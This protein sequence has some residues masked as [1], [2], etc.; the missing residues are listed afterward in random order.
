[1]LELLRVSRTTAL[2]A[3]RA[4]IH[5]LC[6]PDCTPAD[7]NALN[8]ASRN[9][10]TGWVSASPM[11]RVSCDDADTILYALAHWANEP[12]YDHLPHAEISAAMADI[13][14]AQDNLSDRKRRWGHQF[15]HLL[16]AEWF[17]GVIVYGVLGLLF[18][19]WATLYCLGY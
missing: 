15:A 14:R 12:N 6:A 1:M 4:I 8:L 10:A 17:A 11:V 3:E 19:T 7:T 5:R 18:G 2:M 16:P 13:F 9:L